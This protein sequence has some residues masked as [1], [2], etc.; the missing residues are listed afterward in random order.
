MYLQMTLNVYKY[1]CPYD[2]FVYGVTLVRL[3]IY[4]Y[5]WIYRWGEELIWFMCC[6]YNPLNLLMFSF[7]CDEVIPVLEVVRFPSPNLQW[8]NSFESNPNI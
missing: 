4:I 5:I 3:Y 1:T 7:A 2:I 6:D 8:L